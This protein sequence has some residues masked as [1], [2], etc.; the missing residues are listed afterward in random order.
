[1]FDPD[2]KL[3]DELELN[4][5]YYAILNI[6]KDANEE[7]IK[8]A[9]HRMCV[10]YHP[11]KH[12]DPKNQ[13][14]AVSIFN[15][16]HKAYEVLSNQQKRLIYNLYGQK[17]LDAGWEVIERIRTPQEIL[18]EYERLQNEAEK[19]RIEQHTNPNGTTTLMIDAT[20]LFKNNEVSDD[21]FYTDES[22]LFPNIEIKEMS[23]SQ[24]IEAPLTKDTTA[25]LSG[26]LQNVNG[27]GT[28]SVNCMLRRTFS[29]KSFGEFEL[30]VGDSTS[31][32]LKGYHNLGKKM[33]GNLSLN[34]AFRQSMLSAGVQAMI[35]RQLTNHTTGYV[36][37]TGGFLSSMSSMVVRNTE[38]YHASAQLQ[39]NLKNPFAMIAYTHKFNEDTKAKIRIKCG[40]LGLHL[41]YGCEHKVTSLSKLGAYI[42]IGNA[43]GVSLEIR[44]HRHTQTFNFPI[45]LSEVFSTSAV[46]YGTITPIVVYF[47]VRAFVIRPILKRQNEKNWK[48]NCEKFS[49]LV[50]EKKQEALD[51]ISLMMGVY[52]RNVSQ[53]EQRRGLIITS[54]WYGKFTSDFSC[55]ATL[56]QLT[57]VTIPVQCLVR[58]SK[59][60][61]TDATKSQL[62]GFYDP[63]PGE[64]KYLKISY[65]F[66]DAVHEAV[67]NDTEH[68][69]IPK[70][71][72]RI[73]TKI[74]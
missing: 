41:L 57:N 42:S 43:S 26:T 62:N 44:L 52:Q 68:V 51:A 54:A 6:K 47:T 23:I 22:S 63:C 29:P 39:L 46:F 69:R 18:Q 33:A 71:S 27:I 31:I 37:W 7:E 34:L 67:F 20:D 50:A 24:S 61:L 8:A 32:R 60:I 48:D 30:G 13:Q 12:Q 11:D 65:E 45:L 70:Q 9:Y 17:G 25:I 14:I 10:I 1:M 3:D 72:H 56:S 15:K 49:K 73:S 58:D 4:P 28:G 74:S 53:E 59:L 55:N 40:F 35:S 2:A 5:D 66:R 21:P 19:R 16:I 64:D 36:T 38:K